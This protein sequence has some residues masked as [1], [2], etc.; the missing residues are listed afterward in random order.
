MSEQLAPS[1]DQPA[2]DELDR[3]V[4]VR[5]AQ[6]LKT[7]AQRGQ[8]DLDQVWWMG[9]VRDISGNGIG[10]VLQQRFEPDT[11]LTLELENAARTFSHTIHVRVIRATPCPGGWL[12][13]CAFATDM[14]DAEVRSLLR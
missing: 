6:K 2:N 5:H 9:S 3:R 4:R 11:Y 7:Y 14:S 1:R 12:L 13:G 8:G 10:I